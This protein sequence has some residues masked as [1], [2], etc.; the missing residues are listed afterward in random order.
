LATNDVQ[1]WRGSRLSLTGGC[2]ARNLVLVVIPGC[3][4]GVNTAISLPD[5]PFDRASARA[6]DLGKSVTRHIDAALDQLE[7]IDES[8]V[9]AVAKGHRVLAADD[10]E[11]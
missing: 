4:Q 2:F 6:D 10:D 8:S 3:T 11:W 5:G 9:D 7:A 1:W